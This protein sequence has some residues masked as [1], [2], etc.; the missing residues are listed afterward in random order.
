MV[1]YVYGNFVKQTAIDMV[2]QGR[3]ILKIQGVPRD[4]LCDI[5][6]LDVLPGQIQRIDFEVEDPANENSCLITYFQGGMI[7]DGEEGLKSQL[8]NQIVH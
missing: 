4:S 7:G 5:R 8:L 6:C 2:E 3:K 1:W